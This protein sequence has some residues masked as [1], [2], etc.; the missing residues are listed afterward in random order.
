MG[1][2]GATMVSLQMGH[3]ACTGACACIGMELEAAAGATCVRSRYP[4]AAATGVNRGGPLDTLEGR[5]RF[6]TGSDSDMGIPVPPGL[7]QPIP[8]PPR[9]G[10]GRRWV[11]DAGL[12]T[13][14]CIGPA[15]SASVADR[16]IAGPDEVEARGAGAAALTGVWREACMC[17]RAEE[18]QIKRLANAKYELH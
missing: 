2:L 13:V 10:G 15:D 3:T 7:Y 1:V 4:V 11:V 12:V 6:D 17:Q 18:G 8:E 14:G 5:D 16:R 9:A